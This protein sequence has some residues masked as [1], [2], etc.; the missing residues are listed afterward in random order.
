MRRPRTLSLLALAI[1]ALA[2]AVP[3]RAWAQ[4]SLTVTAAS[5]Y[6]FRG[7]SLSQGRPAVSV[8]LAYDFR[9]GAYAGASAT[10][11]D[12]P[13]G[14]VR[15][16]GETVYVGFAHQTP[17][18]LTLDIGLVHAEFARP[19]VTAAPGPVVTDIYGYPLPSQPAALNVSAGSSYSEA[20]AGVI[21]GPVS[22]RLYLS[23]DYFGEGRTTAYL[24]LNASV[25][26]QARTRLFAH[27]GMLKPL[28]GGVPGEKT[29]FDVRAG[30][31]FEF[32]R[33]EVQL[34]WTSAWPRRAYLIGYPQD[35][36]AL[37]LS[38]S[39]YF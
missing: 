4:F 31:A 25:R 28:G 16:V 27:A 37:V 36:D 35:R 38:A 15:A 32:P 39:A 3:A 34:A 13:G 9:G 30:F 19:T 7:Y 2:L 18:G 23:P 24:D 17:N 21:K 11:S 12:P 5:D 6:R 1:P 29:R 14:A 22:A 10:L 20:Y 33:G 26:P 8:G